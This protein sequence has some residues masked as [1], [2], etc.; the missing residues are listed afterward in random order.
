M[1]GVGRGPW[2][3]TAPADVLDGG[4][5]DGVPGGS[6]FPVLRVMSSWPP[7]GSLVVRAARESDLDRLVAFNLA[8][9]RET[10]DHGLDESALRTGMLRALRDR[11]R[12]SYSMAELDGAVVGCLLVTREWSDWRDRWFWWIQSVY[13]APQARR[14]GVYRALHRAVLAAAA[15]QGDVCGV[16]LYVDAANRA[17]QATYA[18]LGMQ[19]ARYLMFE[20]MLARS[21]A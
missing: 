7:M 19:Q 8:M 3:D 10:E 2:K 21:P 6:L 11:E 14:R 1:L 20:Q 17:A 15:E 12:G 16:R 18:E 5:G 13:V 4:R 9:A